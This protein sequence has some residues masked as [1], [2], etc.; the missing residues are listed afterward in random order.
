MNNFS[1][2]NFVGSEWDFVI[3]STVRSLPKSSIEKKPTKG[4]KYRNLGLITDTQQTNIALT[5]AR[6]GFIIIGMSEFSI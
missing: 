4:W 3:L 5:R 1:A 2:H 6:K